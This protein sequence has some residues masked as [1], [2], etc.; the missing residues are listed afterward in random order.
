MQGKTFWYLPGPVRIAACLAR[1]TPT[2]AAEA[3]TVATE[4]PTPNRRG[5]KPSPRTAALCEFCYEK[6]A[7]GKLKRAAICKLAAEKFPG[8]HLV[9]SDV[10]TNAR[11]HATDKK[12]PWPV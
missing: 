3:A 11:R 8:Y 12:R 7:E 2:V 6:L 10:T 1:I 4:E 5:R 9:E